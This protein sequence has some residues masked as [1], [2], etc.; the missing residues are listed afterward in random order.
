MRGGGLGLHSGESIDFTIRGHCMRAPCDGES[1]RVHKRAVYWPGDVLVVRGKDRWF[2][3][4]FVGYVPSRHGWLA[5]TRADRGGQADAASRASQ[6][7]G[8]VDTEVR[9]WDRLGALRSYGCVLAR[10]LVEVTG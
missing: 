7:V 8:R 9:P 5:L 10:R 6:I 2:A 3:H 4:R 1:V